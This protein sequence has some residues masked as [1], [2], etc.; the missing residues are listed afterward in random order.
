MSFDLAMFKRT[1]EAMVVLAPA[2]EVHRLNVDC[3]AK[4]LAITNDPTRDAIRLRRTRKKGTP[5]SLYAVKALRR[6]SGGTGSGSD[7]GDSA[8]DCNSSTWG[9]RADSPSSSRG[10][11]P[12]LGMSAGDDVGSSDHTSRIEEKSD[13][14]SV[15]VTGAEKEQAKDRRRSVTFA[16][17][18]HGEDASTGGG[19]GEGKDGKDGKEDSVSAARFRRASLD[20]AA[21]TTFA[22]SPRS[23]GWTN[24]APTSTKWPAAGTALGEAYEFMRSEGFT[25]GLAEDVM[26]TKERCPLRYWLVD[27]SASMKIGDGRKYTAYGHVACSRWEELRKVGREGREERVREREREQERER[28]RE[29]ERV[30]PSCCLRYARM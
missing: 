8:S 17:A 7:V 19:A 3:G 10:A 30:P 11:S 9:S 25:R 15:G 22:W 12:L 13:S 18:V 2:E 28:A 27:N 4:A 23:R 26:R 29:R 5:F 20:Y 21:P 1:A 6:S 14:K 16:P 24:C